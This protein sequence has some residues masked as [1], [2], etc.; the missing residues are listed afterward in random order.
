MSKQRSFEHFWVILLS[1]VA[2][3]MIIFLTAM[4]GSAFIGYRFYV[5]TQEQYNSLILTL[6]S[7]VPRDNLKMFDVNGI[8]I[9]QLM[10]RGLHTSVTYDQ[11]AQNM[12]NAT[13][14]TEDKDFWTNSG[15][16][17]QRIIQA[18]LQD[19]EKGHVVEGGSTITQQLIK[20]LVLQNQAQDITR[21]LQEVVLTPQ[22]NSH[23]SKQAIMEMYLNSIYYGEQAY[24]VDTAANVYF[25]LEDQPGKSAASQLDL[26]QAAM[27]AGLPSAPNGYN[28]WVN[29]DAA[30]DRLT[31]VLNLMHR[32]G[33]ITVDQEQ[34]A[35]SEARS[36][37]FLKRPTDLTQPAPQ[38]FDFVLEQLEKQ[39]HMTRDQLSLSDMR[40]YTTLDLKL[41]NQILK[42]AQAQV[43]SLQGSNVTN[44]AEVLIDYHTGAVRTLLGNVHPDTDYFDVATDGYRQPGSSF[45]PYV[46]VTAFEQGVSPGQAVDDTPLSIP[47]SGRPPFR[48]QNYSRSF[49]GHMTLRCALQNSLNIPTVK[50]IEH[51]GVQNAI[52]TMQEM[53]ITDYRGDLNDTVALGSLA[54]HLIDHTSAIGTFADGGVHVPYYTI[55]KVEFANTHRVF[56]HAQVPGTR[57]ISPQLAYMM[58]DVLRDNSDRAPEFGYCNP[59]NLRTDGTCYGPVLPSAAKTGTTDNFRD[60]W[61]VGYTSDYVLGVW[62]GNNNDLPMININGITGAAPIW[63][64]AMLAAEAGHSPQPFTNPGGM[65]KVEQHYSDGVA[66]DDWYLAGQ[67]PESVLSNKSSS[68]SLESNNDHHQQPATVR[69]YCGSYTFDSQPPPPRSQPTDG[70]VPPG[71]DWW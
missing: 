4:S 25:G 67:V 54:V 11:I 71:Q 5:S 40:V 12:I 18:A 62:V 64:D 2:A 17:I 7:F 28:P 66:T 69:P 41:Q 27:L 42:I 22:I 21:K 10:D 6:R 70:H 43:A 32:D 35:L 38:F 20:N 1:A 26:A 44:A 34:A 56:E 49:Y 53:G 61:T 13:V 65:V 57:V 16:N 19:L 48:P 14:S 23:Y 50:V 9:G 47:Q 30:I 45:K 63:H 39:F 46:Y 51:V 59:L 29:L 52:N 37:G 33:Y 24:G 68:K 58:T 8:P 55:Q 15:I 31:E 36:P 3:V 60:T